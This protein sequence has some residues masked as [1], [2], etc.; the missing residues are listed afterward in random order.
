MM[1]RRTSNFVRAGI[2]A[3][4]LLSGVAV[5]QTTPAPVPTP[6]TRVDET[7]RQRVDS[8]P[9]AFEL[10]FER[11][12]RR[13]E[14]AY[15]AALSF[16]RCVVRLN[17]ERGRDLLGLEV[18]SRDEDRAVRRLSQRYSA[19]AVSAEHVPVAFL[20]GAFA[21]QLAERISPVLVPSTTLDS[22]RYQAFAASVPGLGEGASEALRQ[23]VD[24][25]RCQ[26]ALVPEAVHAVLGTDIGSASERDALMAIYAAA[27]V[28]GGATMPEGVSVTLQRAVLAEALY[29]W[30]QS[31]RT[32]RR[33]T[34]R[35]GD[36]HHA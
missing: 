33:T 25:A 9:F 30:L 16:A 20:R 17:E 36:E 3:L 11:D 24:S 14:R 29:H 2:A 35:R 22:A 12:P 1:L 6:P 15:E 32:P 7:P 34:A 27:P 8:V 5:A 23:F 26:S 18:R 13:Q 21:E 19:C 10:Y 31:D 28:C 4:G